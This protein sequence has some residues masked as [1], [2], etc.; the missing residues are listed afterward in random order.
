M[1][2]ALT[3]SPFASPRSRAFNVVSAPQIY[4]QVFACYQDCCSVHSSGAFF[5][6]T[7]RCCAR[8]LREQALAHEGQNDA[9][10]AAFL[11]LEIYLAIERH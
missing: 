5:D 3:K 4:T 7:C 8:S 10:R 1:S 11:R 9:D 6:N 2:G